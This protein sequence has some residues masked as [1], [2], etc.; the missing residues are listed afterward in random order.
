MGVLRGLNKMSQI[1]THSFKLKLPTK[2]IHVYQCPQWTAWEKCTGKVLWDFSVLWQII[3]VQKFLYSCLR[4]H[5]GQSQVLFFVPLP[6]SPVLT[7]L[8]PSGHLTIFWVLIK[9]TKYF[10]VPGISSW[11]FTLLIMWLKNK[12]MFLAK[13]CYCHNVKFIHSEYLLFFSIG[14]PADLV[15]VLYAP[16]NEQSFYFT[17]KAWARKFKKDEGKPHDKSEEEKKINFC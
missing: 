2:H 4:F 1:V 9:Q 11:S 8:L 16:K 3:I 13:H 5:C 12:C 15:L 10:R 17:L 6:L 7:L 14:S